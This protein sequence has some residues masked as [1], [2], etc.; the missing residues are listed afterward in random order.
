MTGN[1]LTAENAEN[2][3]GRGRAGRMDRIGEL[4]NPKIEG[5]IVLPTKGIL[6][7]EPSEACRR[8]C[9]EIENNSRLAMARA[10]DFIVD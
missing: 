8:A 6:R 2:A 4:L 1:D 9:R 10:R 3:E 7:W 5:E